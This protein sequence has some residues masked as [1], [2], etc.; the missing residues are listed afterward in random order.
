MLFDVGDI[1]CYLESNF[2]VFLHAWTDAT[3]L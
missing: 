2:D 1:F 3:A